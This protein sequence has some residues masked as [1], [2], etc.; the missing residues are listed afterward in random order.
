MLGLATASAAALTPS[1]G[2]GQAATSGASALITR[3]I[4]KTGEHLPVIGLGTNNFGAQGE[5][6]IAPRREVIRRLVASGATVIDTSRVYGRGRSEE[7]IGQIIGELGIRQQVF[8]TTKALAENRQVAAAE[9][10]T[11]MRALGVGH[12]PAI[13][14]QSLRRPDV[15]LPVLR[16]W[17][18]AGRIRYL[19]GSSSDESEYALAERLIREES[20]D[21]IQIDYSVVNRR[22]GESILPLARDMGVAVQVNEPF[23]GRKGN[24]LPRLAGRPLPGFAAEIGATSW[25]QLALKYILAN[26]VVTVVVPGTTNPRH[27]DDNLAAGRGV[28]PD[29]DMRRRIEQLFDEAA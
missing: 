9:L 19:G 22:P 26:P 25:A 23:G 6:Q 2:R 4:P 11:S 3:A 12:V 13:L 14:V 7:V 10:E 24:V 1:P 16:E 18:Q 8:I 29:A 17:K 15:M 20:L 27:V 21:I 28:L 5:E